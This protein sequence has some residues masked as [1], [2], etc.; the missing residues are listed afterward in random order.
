MTKMRTAHALILAA[1]LAAAPAAPP[2]AAQE[3]PPPEGDRSLGEGLDLMQEGARIILRRMMREMQPLV[4]ELGALIDDLSAYHPPEMLP[5]GDII[6]RRKV[7]LVPQLP[8][9][10]GEEGEVEL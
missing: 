5:N 3:G 8:G 7:P 10:G 6:L 2:A 9:A 1:I 4:Q